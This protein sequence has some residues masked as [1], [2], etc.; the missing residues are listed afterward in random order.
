M[1][2]HA[3][4]GDASAFLTGFGSTVSSDCVAVP[5]TID[6]DQSFEMLPLVMYN[7]WLWSGGKLDLP[8]KLCDRPSRTCVRPVMPLLVAIGKSRKIRGQMLLLTCIL[9]PFQQLLQSPF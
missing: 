3:Q 8:L 9:S 7:W 4:K 2:C 6:K 5:S 1:V